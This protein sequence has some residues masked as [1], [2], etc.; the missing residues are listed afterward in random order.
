VPV[1]FAVLPVVVLGL[2]AFLTIRNIRTTR[3]TT[4][5]LERQMTRVLMLQT[6]FAACCSIP[7]AIVTM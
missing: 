4:N 6:V 1:V 3:Q 7:V 2:F 5:Q